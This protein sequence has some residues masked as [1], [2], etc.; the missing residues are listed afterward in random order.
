MIADQ[1]LYVALA[2][3]LLITLGEIAVAFAQKKVW[4]FR[5]SL[6]NLGIYAGGLTLDRLASVTINVV[7][8]MYA[9]KFAAAMIPNTVVSMALLFVLMDFIYY[10]KHRWEHELRVFWAHHSVHH[11]SNH[12]NFS[13]A[14]RVGWLGPL[15]GWIYFIPPVLLGFDPLA[16]L[17]CYKFILLLQFWV[18]SE[19][20]G[21]LGFLEKIINTPSNHR[22]HHGSDAKY[23][24]KNYG[25]VFIFWD[26]LFG[27]YQEEQETPRYGLV[28][29]V[30]L[31]N[32]IAII[33][34]EPRKLIQDMLRQKNWMDSMRLLYKNPGW[35][36]ETSQQNN[37]ESVQK[38]S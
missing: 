29:P 14:L 17:L 35:T 22:V 24:D 1:Y 32:P 23:L 36:P 3:V 2:L 18:H 31:Y 13:T 15:Y 12:F 34:N 6:A 30:E 9:A 19:S 27:T 5:D 26:L 8:L 7:V 20:I 21:K 38:V 25:G 16:V 33:L 10:W 4:N 11:N 37:V 28:T